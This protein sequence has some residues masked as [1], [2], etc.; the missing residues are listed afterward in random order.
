MNTIFLLWLIASFLSLV[1]LIVFAYRNWQDSCPKVL[2]KN[3]VHCT[4]YIHIKNYANIDYEEFIG[5]V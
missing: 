1:Y 2:R 3:R 5:S 4:H